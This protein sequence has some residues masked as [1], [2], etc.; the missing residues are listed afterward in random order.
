MDYKNKLLEF[1]EA[2]KGVVLTKDIIAEG[3]P[4]QYI[5]NLVKEGMLEKVAQGVYLSSDAFEDE[6]YVIQATNKKAIFSHETALYLHDLT[7]RDPLKWVVTTP[8]GYNAT[9]LKALG[10]NVH[11][12]KKELHELGIVSKQT[13]FGR[14]I[15]TYDIERMICDIVRNRNTMDAAILNDAIKRYVASKDKNIPRLMRYAKLFR[16]ESVLRGYLQV[17]L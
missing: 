17:L 16:V 15:L 6:M 7:D 4:K 10:I 2:H 5:Y 3:I 13:I 11:Y 14:A 1:I 9:H 12:I 8:S